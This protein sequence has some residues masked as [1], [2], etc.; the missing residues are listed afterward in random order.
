VR[1]LILVLASIGV[2]VLLASGAALAITGGNP[3]G[4]G[5]PYV[6]ALVDRLGAYCS[7]TLVPGQTATPV[8]L[9]GAHCAPDRGN[10]VYVTLASKYDAERRAF[11]GGPGVEY[12]G[13]FHADTINDIAIVTF[14]PTDN[15]DDRGYDQDNSTLKDIPPDKLA[16]LPAKGSLNNLPKE[17]KFTAVGYGATSGSSNDYGERRYAVSTFKS[18]DRTYLRLSQH[19]GS[20]G[21][22]YGDSG[23]PNFVGA[24]TAET[25]VIASTT[26]TGD[27]WCKATNVTLRL[28]TQSVREFL[29]AQGVKLPDPEAQ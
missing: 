17:Q 19:N 23:G 13:T 12:L 5:H 15:P 8:F 10:T 14:N 3:D 24:G 11:P 1:R 9:T 21:T 6:G 26:I 25:K 20:G 28:D 7:G 16:Q 2:A 29:S 4:N 22:C 18:V 27:T